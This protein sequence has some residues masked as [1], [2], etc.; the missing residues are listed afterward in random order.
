VP[1]TED[2]PVLPPGTPHVIVSKL[3]LTRAQKWIG[4]LALLLCVGMSGGALASQQVQQGSFESTT[5]AGHAAVQ[6]QLCA[7]FEP[8]ASLKAPAGDASNPSRLFDQQLEAK[9]A[10][11]APV[12]KCKK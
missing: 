11:V 5:A 12:L 2:N 8:I 3:V 10:E 1:G 7:I 9:L 4:G 6:K